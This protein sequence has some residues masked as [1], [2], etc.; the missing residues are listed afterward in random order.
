MRWPRRATEKASWPGSKARE[1]LSNCFPATV[2]ADAIAEEYGV[3]S[4]GLQ[5][6]VESMTDQEIEQRLEELRATQG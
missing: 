3:S 4:A 2:A 6:R 1:L 5:R